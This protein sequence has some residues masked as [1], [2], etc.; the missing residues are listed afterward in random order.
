MFGFEIII[1]V[2]A[3]SSCISFQLFLFSVSIFFP[4][5]Q[6][7]PVCIMVVVLN[8]FNFSIKSFWG[9][10]GQPQ[11][12]MAHVALR[13][14][15]SLHASDHIWMMWVTGQCTSSKCHWWQLGGWGSNGAE[16][17][18]LLWIT[19]YGVIE[20]DLNPFQFMTLLS[21]RC[22]PEASAPFHFALKAIQA[23]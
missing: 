8:S 16:E 2:I 22:I 13:K 18:R 14:W 5:Y 3:E 17:K 11:R 15:T 10:G 12:C 23:K 7:F 20:S 1:S 9:F 19:G 6:S 21:Q 4:Q